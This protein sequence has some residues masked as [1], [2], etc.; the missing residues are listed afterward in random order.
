MRLVYVVWRTVFFFCKNI[1]FPAQAEYSHFSTDV[2]LKIFLL[3]SS[4]M[5]AYG[6]SVLECIGVT[7]TT[8]CFGVRS[9][10]CH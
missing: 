2:W 5:I 9:S 10:N 3:I 6:I 8:E 1:V 7:I 4:K